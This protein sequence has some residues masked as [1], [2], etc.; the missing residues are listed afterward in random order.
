[1]IPTR[2]LTTLLIFS[3]CGAAQNPPPSL[4]TIYNFMGGSDGAGPAAP[5]I[6]GSSGVLYGTTAHGGTADDG[7][8]F[9]LSPPAVP[10]GPW[11]HTLLYSFQGGSDGISPNSRLIVAGGGVLYG[12]TSTGGQSGEGMV[13]SLTPPQIAGRCVG[14]DDDP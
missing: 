14:R 13:F 6:I 7:T 10:G 11:T 1:M 9:S 3:A 5:L 2:L 12:T 4:T 8:V